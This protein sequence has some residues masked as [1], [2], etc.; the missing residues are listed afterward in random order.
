M[1]TCITAITLLVFFGMSL[2]P[3]WITAAVRHQ[4]KV[5][6]DT[7][8]VYFYAKLDDMASYPGGLENFYSFLKSNYK[9]STKPEK[10]ERVAFL[11]IVEA[12]GKLSNVEPT[13]DNEFT[14]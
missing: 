10:A 7:T 13:I 8:G 11:F 5:T 4:P 9:F 2:S 6:M 1:K 3:L 14:R 12:N